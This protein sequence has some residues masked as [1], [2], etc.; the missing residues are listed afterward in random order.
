MYVMR[1]PGY[2][3]VNGEDCFC[4]AGPHASYGGAVAVE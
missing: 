4:G 1:I 3:L 2:K